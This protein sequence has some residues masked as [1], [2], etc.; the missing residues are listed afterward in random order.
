MTSLMRR[1]A[2]AVNFGIIYGISDF[3]LSQNLNVSRAQAGAFIEQYFAKFPGVRSYMDQAVAFA[4]E[5]GYTETVLGRRRDL[6]GIHSRNFNERSFAERTAMNTPIQGT[7]A[8]MIKVAMIRLAERLRADRLEAR[9]LL[10]VHDELIVE[11]PAREVEAVSRHMAEAM[12]QAIELS[13]PLR[14]DLHVGDTWYDA[15]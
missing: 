10:Q 11:C 9:M 2:K 14:V 13:V 6:P 5:H 8:D 12:E 3:G 7:A 1:Q 15:K 4:K